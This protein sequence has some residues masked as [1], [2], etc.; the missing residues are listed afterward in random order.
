MMTMNHLVAALVP[1]DTSLTSVPTEVQEAH[2]RLY[3]AMKGLPD[4][5]AYTK[6]CEQALHLVVSESNPVW[7]LTVEDG[8]VTQAAVRLSQ[9]WSIRFQSF[10]NRALLPMSDLTGQGALHAADIECMKRG[11]MVMLP[12]DT[13][14]RSVICVD[15]S[16]LNT[17]L[18]ADSASQWQ[19]LQFYFFGYLAALN[20]VSQTKV[21]AITIA[22]YNEAA[23]QDHLKVDEATRS[24]HRVSPSRFNTAF[25]CFLSHS[26]DE[27][28]EG[29]LR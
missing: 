24:I 11:V 13:Q 10:G 20:P 7:F 19:R 16:R 21:G 6:A 27:T 12:K 25:S 28:F 18:Y 9:Y 1:S 15:Y 8:H 29:Q 23:T 26:R 14:G 3:K 2:E 5:A 17:T 22:I 4:T